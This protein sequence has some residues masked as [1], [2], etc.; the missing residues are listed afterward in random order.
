MIIKRTLKITKIKVAALVLIIAFIGNIG[1]TYGPDTS[2]ND[3][4]RRKI[5]LKFKEIYKDG[6]LTNPLNKA[7]EF[8]EDYIPKDD[9]LNSNN[10]IGIIKLAACVGMDDIVQELI[11]KFNIKKDILCRKNTPHSCL[12]N[13]ILHLTAYYG[14]LD[15]LRILFEKHEMK[16]FNDSINGSALMAALSKNRVNIWKRESVRKNLKNNFPYFSFI[17]CNIDAHFTQYN[18][19]TYVNIDHLKTANYI[20]DNSGKFGTNID[21]LDSEGRSALSLALKVYS[22]D[23]DNEYK[24]KYRDL[25]DK[26]ISKSDKNTLTKQDVH[27]YT[28]LMIA[29]D[30]NDIES[31]EA[32]LKKLKQLT[33][34]YN[35][36]FSEKNSALNAA[37]FEGYMPIVDLLLKYQYPKKEA[38]KE[39]IKCA[40][41]GKLEDNL[42]IV[43][44]LVD[45]YPFCKLR[46]KLY[47]EDVKNLYS[48]ILN[49]SIQSGN[50]HCMKYALSK[51]AKVNDN[52]LHDAINSGN[53]LVIE[54]TMH[55]M[56]SPWMH[57]S[58]N[59][60]DSLKKYK[61]QLFQIGI[62]LFG[63]GDEKESAAAHR[64]I[65][66]LLKKGLHKRFAYTDCHGIGREP[67]WHVV[68]YYNN[69]NR[70]YE[71]LI[72]SFSKYG[73]RQ[74]TDNCVEED[75]FRLLNTAISYEKSKAMRSGDIIL[76]TKAHFPMY[77]IRKGVPF[78]SNIAKKLI[79]NNPY[80]QYFMGYLYKVQKTFLKDHGWKK[81]RKECNL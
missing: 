5:N 2:Y 17:Q 19:D 65:K 74:Y 68:E 16:D 56:L 10:C 72:K 25:I 60:I 67:F 46:N 79:K 53:I 12:Q 20:L 62:E 76:N 36:K 69:G 7:W 13:S 50:I 14:Q 48:Q 55:E 39:A 43:K 26:L 71:E 41:E 23:E 70:R 78:D 34:V 24:K 21:I 3:V 80:I 15:T 4:I 58:W 18:N 63:S 31:V 52:S 29:V 40:I 9:S 27:S 66:T 22:K 57:S 38:Y 75:A 32:I 81:F 1:C 49:W 47:K 30:N 44:L 73:L 59:K 37:A 28:P 61:T 51:K 54:K 45:Q 77:L 35:G 42:K 8:I 11:R 64:I 33:N 6:K